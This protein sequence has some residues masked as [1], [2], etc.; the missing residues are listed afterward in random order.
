MRK[1]LLAALVCVFVTVN[2]K[3]QILKGI[4]TDSTNNTPLM[5]ASILIKGSK[6]IVQTDSLGRF[7][8]K[9][10]KTKKE[11][12]VNYI[13]Y[14]TK[15]I[16]IVKPKLLEVKLQKSSSSLDEVVVIG[17]GTVKRRDVTGSVTK[18]YYAASSSSSPSPVR[19]SES[20]LAGRVSGIA[21]TSSKSKS[22]RR[23][24]SLGTTESYK[25]EAA[26][27]IKKHLAT[28][29][30]DKI[31][32]PESD[33]NA[34]I[35]TAGEINDFSK[36]VLWNDKSQEELRQHKKEWSICPSMRYSVMVQN[37]EGIAMVGKEVL[38]LDNQKDTI[39]KAQTDNVGKAEL[40]ANMFN[41]QYA[42]D[43]KFSIVV[44]TGKDVYS[45]KRAKQFQDGINQITIK[46]PC[47]NV[48]IVEAAFV[49]DAT[50]SMGDEIN[51]LK[52][53]LNDVISKVKKNNP[54]FSLRLGSVFYRDI[55]Q[56][57]EF[58]TRQSELTTDIANTIN[59]IKM[60]NAGGG[61][62]YPEAVDA[63]LDAAINNLKWSE[64]ALT[65]LIFLILDA[66]PHQTPDVIERMQKLT[67]KAAAM[68]IKIIPITSSGT[69]KT[70]EYLMRS[71]ALSTNGTYVFLT[72]DSGVGDHHIAPTTDKYEVEKLNAVLIRLFNQYTSL[73]TCKKEMPKNELTNLRDTTKINGFIKADTT[74]KKNAKD[75]LINAQKAFSC[76]FFPNPTSGILNIAINGDVNEMFLTDISGKLLERYIVKGKKH[77]QVNIAQYPTGVYLMT[78]FGENNR[79]IS[80]KIVLSK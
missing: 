49:V 46:A 63:G 79:P 74:L 61:G 80:G 21:I 26:S 55:N 9:I 78:Y 7:K 38:L 19:T 35:L 71:L 41:E 28:V 14:E 29:E 39:W 33:V 27:S 12:I 72:D 2:A 30:K 11:L 17:Y 47:K 3:S 52:V 18:A 54:N 37:E 60:Q 66:P 75:T 48:D 1:I 23:D 70:T 62:D 68:G 69:D 6:T 57:D 59:F 16:K 64:N 67:A 77:L 65:K 73:V 40:W 22:S 53:E 34:G 58:V 32:E 20:A 76:S 51:Y 50:G 56:G 5:G 13:G 25:D 4:I 36:W 31:K 43:G 24:A 42:N 44:N 15:M 8:I 45:I 10:D